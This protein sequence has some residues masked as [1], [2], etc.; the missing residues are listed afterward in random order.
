[1]ARCYLKHELAV[2]FSQEGE[3]LVLNRLFEGKSS[4]FYIDVGAHHPHRLSNTYMFYLEGWRGIN[5]DAAPGSMSIFKK[6]RPTDINLEVAIS[7]KEE[8]LEYHHFDKPAL[9]GFSSEL[10]LR[11]AA[12]GAAR[13]L[14]KTCIATQTLEAILDEHLP[15]GQQIDF[16]SV[17]VEGLD[18]R[19]I[20][21]SN[22]SK[23]RPAVVV[24][25]D[26][27]GKLIEDAITT[28]IAR[29]LKSVEYDLF[30]KCVT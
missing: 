12:S 21:S 5:I 24:C 25:E 20:R 1:L 15:S 11:R 29:F 10:S 28:P 7:D 9:N 26:F 27:P 2:A 14:H 4:G 17:D 8:I 16:L 13:F 18:E 23:Y 30:G 6:L 3:D 19:V 22:W